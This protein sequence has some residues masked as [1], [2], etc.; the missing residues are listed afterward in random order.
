M[1]QQEIGYVVESRDF[2]VYLDGFPTIHI[3]DMVCSE[4][5]LRGWVNSLAEDKIEVLMVDEGKITPGQAFRKMPQTLSI[6]AGDF[7]LGRAINPLGI[8]IDGKG[9]LSKTKGSTSLELEQEARGIGSREFIKEQFQTGITLIDMLIPIGK[10]QRELILGDAH[11]GKTSFLIDVIANQ[12]Y[13][14][15]ICIYASIGKQV[16]AVK[17]FLDVLRANKAL[18]YTVVIAA[19]SMEA[20]PLIFL[21]PK[22]AFS[23]A[24]YFQKKGLDV[25]VILDDL[26]IHAKIY[27]EMS[28]LAGKSPGRESYP[29]DIFYQ[30]AH[31]IERAGKFKPE[32]GGG[33][34]TALPII[35][36]NLT[37]F[38]TY[39]PTNLMS[40]TDGHWMFKS[41]LHNLGQRPAIDI[42]LSVSRVGR[43]TQ[44]ILSNLISGRIRQIL[45]QGEELQTISRF[46][47]ELPPQ[48]QRVLLQRDLIQEALK[49]EF[50]TYLPKEVQIILLGLILTNYLPSKGKEFFQINKKNIQSLFTTQPELIAIT[51]ALPKL[52]NEDQLVKMLEEKSQ[53]LD[54]LLTKKV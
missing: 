16:S 38:T 14:K 17:D 22:T 4:D 9:F 24:E 8:P 48:T 51:Q 46:S 2:L 54:S 25:L 29:G 27:R 53:L 12:R 30:H 43:Q 13:T 44:D 6:S 18:T 23:L 49:Q 37:D 31:L 40:M 1:N 36:L 19:T 26:G 20:A 11:S 10:G 45:S 33:S 32:Y 7:L 28:L 5:G 41:V 21:T 15:T 52:Q 47:S 50:L 39:I 34:I 3:N 42:P 35:E